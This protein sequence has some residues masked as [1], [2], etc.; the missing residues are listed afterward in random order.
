MK[1]FRLSSKMLIAIGCVSLISILGFSL[2]G[3][4]LASKQTQLYQM[5]NGLNICFQRVNQSFTALMIRDFSSDFMTKDFRNTTSDCFSE[6]SGSLSA[7]ALMTKSFKTKL[8]NIMSDTHWFSEKIDRVVDLSESQQMDLSQ[9]NIIN[10]YVEIEQIKNSL[11]EGMIAE[12]D[13][14]GQGRT[15]LTVG[16]T[17]SLLLMCASFFILFLKRKILLKEVRSIE[18][19]VSRTLG[20]RDS[21]L[22]AQR[23]F[24]K[25]FSVLEIPKTQSFVIDYHSKL[26]EENF[27]MQDHLV[28][29]NAEGFQPDEREVLDVEKLTRI[30]E[31][32]DFNQAVSMVIDKMKVKA[33]NHGIVVDT[34]IHDDFVVNSESESLNQ[35]IFSI[36]N[37]S[38]ESSLNHNEG[39]RIE[40]KGKPLGSIAYCKF[41]IAGF[42]F[43]ESDLAVLN[44][45]AP[46]DDTNVNL[47]ILSELID[48]ANVKLA[49]KNRHNAKLGRLESEIE[50]IFERATA[51]KTSRVVKGNKQEIKQ[52]L[53]RSLS[54]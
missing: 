17:L 11:E 27:K 23:I 30:Y 6:V 53:Q 49:V 42:C 31:K 40:I 22:L 26:M 33:F 34:D 10:K 28:K 46:T 47:A 35:L 2:L 43:D 50:L 19:E 45:E 44:G 29:T 25:L 54:I 15:L 52:M 18:D 39:R 16:L 20:E 24:K 51:K 41:K 4:N 21:H 8:N 14:T 38:M 1:N 12:A 13:R 7:K 36:L 48:D 37:Y 9:S 5:A 32:V 3:Q